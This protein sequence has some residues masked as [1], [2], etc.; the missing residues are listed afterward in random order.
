[1]VLGLEAQRLFALAPD[2]IPPTESE[3]FRWTPWPC[4]W[5]RLN[6]K[7][8]PWWLRQAAHTGQLRDGS[9]V[10]PDAGPQ[11]PDCHSPTLTS[12]SAFCHTEN[13]RTRPEPNKLIQREDIGLQSLMSAHPQWPNVF[14]QTPSL[15]KAGFCGFKTNTGPHF[16]IPELIL[17]MGPPVL[18]TE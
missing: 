3:G 7:N 11:P 14:H 10:L 8:Q 17:Q 4:L 6:P 5:L 18:T 15:G 1:M 9:W 12:S 13:S 2:L 16:M